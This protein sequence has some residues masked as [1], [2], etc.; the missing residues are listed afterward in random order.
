[1]LAVGEH[2]WGEVDDRVLRMT[3]GLAGGLGSCQ[4]ELCGALNGGALIIGALNGRTS[5][6]VDDTLCG[7]MVCRY[8]DRFQAEFNTTQCY[9]LQQSGYG[10]EGQWPCST[11]VEGAARILLDVLDETK[12]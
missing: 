6:D 12:P 2:L 4:Q 8:R 9:G 3:T 1:M 5:A 11:L 10:S 7:E